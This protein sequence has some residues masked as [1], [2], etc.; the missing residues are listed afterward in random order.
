M[1][2]VSSIE[3]KLIELENESKVREKINNILDADIITEIVK[4]YFNLLINIASIEL[5]LILVYV[6]G[7]GMFSL[8]GIN[9]YIL[10]IYFWR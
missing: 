4:I 9:Q 3:S 8:Q 2:M 10:V 5:F 7:W 6:I 1:P